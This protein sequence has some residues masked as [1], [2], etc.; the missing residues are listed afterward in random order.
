LRNTMPP[1]SKIY[2]RGGDKGETSLGGGQRVA[3][4]DLRVEAYGTSDELNAQLGVV[5]AVG[6]ASKELV[7][8]FVDIQNVL[9][10][11]GSDLCFREEDKLKY[12][13]LPKV[14]ERH[15]VALEASIDAMNEVVGPLENFILPGGTPGA[16]QIHVA[17]T[18]CRRAERRL[19]SLTHHEEVSPWVGRYLNRLSDW[20]FVAARFEN[21]TAGVSEPLWNSHA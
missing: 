2:T 12:A 6:L 18:L 16:A 13:G 20:L 1:L 9:F 11:L 8:Q 7:P 17:R 4:D 5:L 10:N 21:R 14:E 19:A 15:V 3:K